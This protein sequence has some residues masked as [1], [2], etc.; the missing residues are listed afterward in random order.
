MRDYLAMIKPTALDMKQYGV[1]GMKWGQ[2]RTS[3]QLRTAAAQRETAPG[4]GSSSGSASKPASGSETSA[5]R[6][7][8]LKTE[9]KAG[10]GSNM[11]DEDLKF[12]NAR[13]EALAKVNKL[14]ESKPG[15]LSETSKKVML[16][17][18][19][20]SMQSVSDTLA[21]KYLVDPITTS[22][23]GKEAAAAAANQAKKAAKS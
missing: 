16:K 13:T 22:I 4:N 6:Y 17:T 7:A 2:R 11:S 18:A 10:L 9:A 14:N 3:A 8:R 12:L 20:K 15:W 21:K 23:I 19:E 1:P 5:A